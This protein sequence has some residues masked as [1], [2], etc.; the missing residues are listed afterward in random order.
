MLRGMPG[1]RYDW[2]AR[3]APV[4]GFA[5]DRAFA[6]NNELHSATVKVGLT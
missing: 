6:G 4:V 3:V 2:I 5:I 1:S